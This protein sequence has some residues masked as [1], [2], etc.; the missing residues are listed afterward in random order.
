[1]R[2][3]TEAQ[4]VARKERKSR[5]VY[6]SDKAPRFATHVN[7]NRNHEAELLYCAA[8]KQMPHG[9]AKRVVVRFMDLLIPDDCRDPHAA[10]MLM[11]EFLRAPDDQARAALLG[12]A[13]EAWGE[14]KPRM[15]IDDVR[16]QKRMP[17]RSLGRGMGS[18][19][20]MQ[21]IKGM[22]RRM[23]VLLESGERPSQPEPEIEPEPEPQW[24]EEEVALGRAYPEPA[25]TPPPQMM[26][27]KPAQTSMMGLMG[28]RR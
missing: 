24:E 25:E 1:M 13:P 18:D 7:W 12:G 19:P 27:R 2:A 21:A 4:E 8:F 28:G 3:M 26:A 23:Q 9:F 10:A 6:P 20:D 16:A 14:D 22:L 5:P 17:R 11:V 15:T